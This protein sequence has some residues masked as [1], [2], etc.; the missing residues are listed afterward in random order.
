MP[1]KSCRLRGPCSALPPQRWVRLR[2]LRD[3]CLLNEHI[4]TVLSEAEGGSTTTER[5]GVSDLACLSSLD[6][7]ARHCAAQ[8][9]LLLLEL[10]FH[11]LAWWQQAVGEAEPR[12]GPDVLAGSLTRA[13]Q[14]ELTREVLMLAW[15]AAREDRVSAALLFGMS[16]PVATLIGSLTPPQIDRISLKHCSAVR[17]RWPHCHQFWRRLVATARAGEVAAMAEVYLYGLQLLGGEA[18]RVQ[19]TGGGAPVG[20]GFRSGAIR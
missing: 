4:L 17:L 6:A 5:S 20:Q 16:A 9:P 1:M 11:D 8:L 14:P 2:V 13:W 3:V 15:P 7:P 10:K 19:Q 12:T 18:L